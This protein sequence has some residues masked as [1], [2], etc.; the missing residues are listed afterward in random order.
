VVV[1]A[2]GETQQEADAFRSSVWNYIQPQDPVTALLVEDFDLILWFRQQGFHLLSLPLCIGELWRVRQLPCA[3][4]GW[5][6][7]VDRQGTVRLH[8]CIG[9]LRA[10]TTTFAGPD[11]GT[12]AVPMTSAAVVV[13]RCL[14]RNSEQRF[15]SAS[16]WT[17]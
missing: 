3:L 4:P 7:Q 14:E 5:F 12:G 6:V 16:D 9:S 11:I 8:W 1:A 13:H 17:F 10:R 2:A 15:Q